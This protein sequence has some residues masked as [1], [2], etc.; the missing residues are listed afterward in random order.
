MSCYSSRCSNTFLASVLRS[1]EIFLRTLWGNPLTPKPQFF[2]C[3]SRISC[4][5]VPTVYLSTEW[6]QGLSPFY[7][8]RRACIFSCFCHIFV[9]GESN[10]CSQHRVAQPQHQQDR[11][12]VG[13]FPRFFRFLDPIL[14]V[15]R[16][17][18]MVRCNCGWSKSNLFWGRTVFQSQSK[19]QGQHLS[20]Q[21]CQFYT[22]FLANLF[23]KLD[24]VIHFQLFQ[25]RAVLC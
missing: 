6:R 7:G 17:D 24:Q 22:V 25:V 14:V 3:V 18:N 2:F 19:C 13:I 16:V 11:S 4:K 20:I 8:P 23:W 10:C 1:L 5:A 21:V 9:F 12:L 15:G